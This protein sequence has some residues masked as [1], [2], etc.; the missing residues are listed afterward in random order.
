VFRFAMIDAAES[1]CLGVV[2]FA[3][4]RLRAGR[5]DHAGIA[6]DLRV[7]SVLEAERE[8]RLPVLFVELAE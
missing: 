4:L 1:E 5:R 6:G 2:A 8:D 3:A 7:V